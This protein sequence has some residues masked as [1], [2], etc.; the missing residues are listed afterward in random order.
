[1]NT[2]K[3]FKTIR[4][5]LFLLFFISIISLVLIS[6]IL[7]TFF[8]ESYY[9]NQNKDFFI[10]TSDDITSRYMIDTK[11]IEQ[12]IEEYGKLNHLTIEI[13]K[14]DMKIEN[15]SIAKNQTGDNLPNEIENI[16]KENIS[17]L[18]D[19]YVYDIVSNDKN[20]NTN[21]KLIFIEKLTDDRYL[22]LS[23]PLKAIRESVKITNKFTL[24]TASITILLGGLVTLI[25]TNRVTKPIIAMNRAAK[26]ISELDF[27]SRVH[28]NSQDEL[29]LL[30][31]SINIMSDKLSLNIDKLQGDIERRKQ[32]VRNISHELKTP[33]SVI[34][35]YSE[36]LKYG[37][38]ETP[39]MIEKYLETIINECNQ[40]D[41]M[42]KEMIELSR[43][44]Y[45]ENKL[46]LEEIEVSILINTIKERFTTI[47]EENQV[48]FIINVNMK[49][50]F[51]CDLK[52]IIRAISNYLINALNHVDQN[53]TITL[54]IELIKNNVMIS[55]FNTGKNIATKDIDKIWDVFYKNDEGRSR[56]IKSGSGLGLSIVREISKLHNGETKV[57]NLQ[58]GVKF[59]LIIPKNFT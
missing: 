20:L 29:A 37:V 22:L 33:I 41:T 48:H 58:N 47:L 40:M 14:D 31:N 2:L 21:T 34:K 35:G 4:V 49:D 42:V 39:Y 26:Q 55:V 10:K 6:F 19:N 45:F 16:I 51:E 27:T 5:K 38:A 8:L 57:E 52:L 44:E 28:I 15:S 25:I 17:T 11:S 36:G 43:Y 18:N 50:S 32:L 46:I 13:V 12:Y 30:G 59:Y 1:M 7:N 54:N 56:E 9:I 23:K 24:F 53:K 3:I